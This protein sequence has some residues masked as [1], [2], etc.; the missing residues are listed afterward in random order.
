MRDYAMV[1]D[2]LKRDLS[3]YPRGS[4]TDCASRSQAAATL[5]ASG[6][7][8]KL[9]PLGQSKDAIDATISKFVALNDA[10]PTV[11][12]R[13]SG[14]DE[15]VAYMLSL[16]QD[17]MWRLLDTNSNGDGCDLAFLAD[18]FRS[19][20][21]ASVKADSTSWYTKFWESN[22][23]HTHPQVLALFR[24]ATSRS[25]TWS[26]ALEHWS[27][28]FR[29]IVVNGNSL[30]TVPKSSEISRTCCT[31]P[32][33]NMVFQQAVGAFIE[34]R[35]RTC[36]GINLSRQ[37]EI[38]RRLTRIGS[39]DGSYGTIDLSS[40]S[41]SIALS[42]VQWSVPPSVL[43]WINL[44]RSPVTRL[45]SGHE[46]ELRMVSTM[47]NGFTFPLETAIFA[48]AVRAVYIAKDINLCDGANSNWSVFGDDMV[49]REDCFHAVITLLKRL[50]FTVNEGK[51]FNSG[52]FRESCGYDYFLGENIRPV[53]VETLE[54]AQDVYSSFNRLSRWSA[55][56][57][58]P[59]VRTLRCLHRMAPDNRVPFSE[60]DDTGFKFP[61][62]QSP[63]KLSS[64]YWRKYKAL[65]PVS[66]GLPVP[67]GRTDAL[68]IGYVDYNPRGWELAY[69][70]LYA[71]TPDSAFKHPTETSDID[72]RRYDGQIM[73]RPMQGE[74]LD[75]KYR[76]RDIPH[77]DWFGAT[78]EGRFHR[79]SFDNWQVVMAT[80]G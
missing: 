43:R 23:S 16:F 18:H 71:R 9:A 28:A 44:F 34:G 75:R 80:V 41:D 58:I 59:L 30:F 1:Y 72:L 20:P 17:E 24:A 21:G 48:S 57:R 12:R 15:S 45:P 22:H 50:G 37:P 31:E 26:A 65:M 53:F 29:P 5:I 40:A 2:L 4:L 8:K 27:K 73:R 74:V 3:D 66:T 77:W 42:L 76:T 79:S 60:G 25:E 49:V 56:N 52:P 55:E 39:I 68:S 35:L 10:I 61:S 46:V 63:W 11:P 69:I 54:T 6:L 78:D 33:L 13:T 51:S 62:C 47:G 19:G 7:Y 70:G 36:F 67:E 32:L 64:R 38:N 14:D